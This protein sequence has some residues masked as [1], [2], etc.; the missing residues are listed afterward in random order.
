MFSVNQI[1]EGVNCGTFVILA[2]RTVGLEIGYQVK[3]VH[4]V[5]HKPARGEFFL[6][7][8]AVVAKRA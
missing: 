3:A 4:P 2:I 5:T 1:V 8:D 7:C 6:P